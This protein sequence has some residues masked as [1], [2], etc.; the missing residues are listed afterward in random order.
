MAE[1]RPPSGPYAQCV[2]WLF[3]RMDDPSA[4][5]GAGPLPVAFAPPRAPVP[6]PGPAQPPPS[7]EDPADVRAAQ[8]WFRAERQRLEDYTNQQFALI[9]Q[10]H[11]QVLAKHYQVEA[12]IA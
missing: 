11:Y 10:Q 7:L 6:L 1:F 9:E 5:P 2:D 3:A 4:G 8:D 12:D